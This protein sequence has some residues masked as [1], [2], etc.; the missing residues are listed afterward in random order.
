MCP[1][2]QNGESS[3]PWLIPVSFKLQDGTSP[4][5]LWVSGL[6]KSP[7][8]SHL[9]LQSP[10]LGPSALYCQQAL[11]TTCPASYKH[12][13]LNKVL[14]APLVLRILERHCSLWYSTEVDKQLAL[15]WL[16]SQSWDILLGRVKKL[17]PEL[18]W[19]FNTAAWSLPFLVGPQCKH[20]DIWMFYN[21]FKEED[22]CTGRLW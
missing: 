2:K 3:S 5:W 9:V 12:S 6:V 14:L 15:N 22:H 4:G 7:Y 16:G 18:C 8:N 19:G 10:G 1:L 21:K 13:Y 17:P 20:S 11:R